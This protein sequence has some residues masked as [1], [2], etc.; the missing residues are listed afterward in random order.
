MFETAPARK[1]ATQLERVAGVLL[2]VGLLAGPAASHLYW[3][4]G[5]TWGLHQENTLGIRVVSAIVLMLVVGAVL[6]VLA[7]VGMW[8]RTL[9]PDRVIRLLAWAVAGVFLLEA[10]AGFTYS[11]G[12]YEWWLYAPVALVLGLLGLVVARSG[13]HGTTP[14]RELHDDL[15]DSAVA[16]G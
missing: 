2:A 10:V 7:R 5:G 3:L 12:D 16:E 4:L 13:L 1:Q 8:Q 9:V 6:V 15:H 14:A 11:R